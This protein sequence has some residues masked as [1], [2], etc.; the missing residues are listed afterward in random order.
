MSEE[1]NKSDKRVWYD[2]TTKAVLGTGN[3]NL[4]ELDGVVC[5]DSIDWNPETQEF[6]QNF[7]GSI[8]GDGPWWYWEDGNLY[9]APPVP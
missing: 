4:V 1:L 5:V 9:S 7:T 8:E 3:I 2:K 6:I